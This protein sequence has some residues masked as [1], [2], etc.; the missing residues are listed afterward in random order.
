[1]LAVRFR[2]LVFVQVNH[3]DQ[4][5]ISV[6]FC[7][8]GHFHKGMNGC[9]NQRSPLASNVTMA[10]YHTRWGISGRCVSQSTDANYPRLHIFTALRVNRNTP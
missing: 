2:K 5:W 1:M 8:M 9:A 3:C 6:D 10:K 4:R 7:I